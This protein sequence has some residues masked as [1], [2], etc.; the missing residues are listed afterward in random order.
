MVDQNKDGTVFKDLQ[1][2]DRRIQEIEKVRVAG[3]VGSEWAV[4]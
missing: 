3:S 1:T 4:S 2:A